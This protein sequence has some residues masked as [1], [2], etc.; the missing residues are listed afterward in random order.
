MAKLLGTGSTCFSWASCRVDSSGWNHGCASLKSFVPS[1]M[2]GVYA[3]SLGG[4]IQEPNHVAFVLVG[5]AVWYDKLL[6]AME[7]DNCV[8]GGHG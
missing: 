3:I 8:L 7:D 4:V 5:L 1:F 2:M 6:N